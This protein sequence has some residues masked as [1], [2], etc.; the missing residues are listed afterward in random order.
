MGTGGAGFEVW[1]KGAK[2]LE[3]DGRRSTACIG[4]GREISDVCVCEE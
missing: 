2:E 3:A 1:A 4:K